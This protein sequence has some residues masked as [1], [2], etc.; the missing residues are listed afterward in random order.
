MTSYRVQRVSDEIK[1]IISEILIKEIPDDR[2]NLLTVTR[3]SCTP[4]L[5]EAKVYISIYN[6][7]A[8]QRRQSL[9]KIIKQGSLIRKLV[10]SRIILKRVPLLHF[11][12]DDTIQY[13][14]KIERLIQQIHE[15]DETG[16]AGT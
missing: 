7:D 3:V 2:G 1:R 15:Q 13:A 4:D 10:G 5:R 11:L 6:E 8:D 16:Q 12:E 14:E 9:R